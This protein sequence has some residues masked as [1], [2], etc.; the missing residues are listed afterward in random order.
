MNT[1]LED[2]LPAGPYHPAPL[3]GPMTRQIPA[4]YY[5]LPMWHAVETL[6]LPKLEPYRD[7]FLPGALSSFRDDFLSTA[8]SIWQAAVGIVAEKL[9]GPL[10]RNWKQW[11]EKTLLPLSP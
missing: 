3:F 9:A 2:L 5:F 1:T 10:P 6:A 8:G 11:L 7:R 4:E